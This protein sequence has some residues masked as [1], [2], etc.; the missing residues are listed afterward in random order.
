MV[1]I[2]RWKKKL[3][4]RFNQMLFHHIIFYFAVIWLILSASSFLAQIMLRK[5]CCPYLIDFAYIGTF[6]S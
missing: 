5:K 6:A 4:N 1:V 2:N 3:L